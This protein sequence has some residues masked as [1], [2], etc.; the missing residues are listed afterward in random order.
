M[1]CCCLRSFFSIRAALDP[2]DNIYYH[3][4]FLFALLAYETTTGRMPLLTVA[5]S[6]VLLIVTPADGVPPMSDGVRAAVY[7]M[8]VVPTLVWLAAKVYLRPGALQR[9]VGRKAPA[10][11]VARAA[12]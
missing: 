1:H 6:V 8:V 2:Q 11:S 10:P 4:P 7:A 12:H 3:L 5:Y 9:V